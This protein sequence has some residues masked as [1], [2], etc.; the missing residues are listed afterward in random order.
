LDARLCLFKDIIENWEVMIGNEDHGVVSSIIENF[1]LRIIP[2]DEFIIKF[3]EI[4]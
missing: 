4:A 3:G 1:E 2:Q